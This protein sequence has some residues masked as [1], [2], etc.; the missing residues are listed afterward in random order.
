MAKEIE[1]H[2]QSLFVETKEGAAPAPVAP[3]APAEPSPKRK[4]TTRRPT[5][6]EPTPAPEPVSEPAQEISSL[7]KL[8]EAILTLEWEISKRSVTVLASEIRSVRNQ[9][10][11]NVTVDFAALAMRV[12]LDYVVKRMSRA[13]PE[14]IRFLLEVADYL[15]SSIE[16]SEEDPLRA[17]HH[18]LMRYENTS[19]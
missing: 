14:S 19:Q 11:D 15:D 16:A 7:R 5:I 13:H 9:Y 4:P 1:R 8:Q 2:L 10:Q 12:V 18:I 17:F 3:A 6:P